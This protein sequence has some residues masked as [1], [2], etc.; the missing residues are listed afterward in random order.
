MIT[1]LSILSDKG[2]PVWIRRW[3]GTAQIMMNILID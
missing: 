1:H 2:Q 3:L